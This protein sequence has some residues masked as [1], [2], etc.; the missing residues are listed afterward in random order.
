MTDVTEGS[1]EQRKIVVSPA[2]LSAAD[3]QYTSFPDFEIWASLVPPGAVW[4]DALARL[5]EVRAS[6]APDANERAVTT[7]MRLAAVDTGALEGLY[8]VDRG[9]TYSVAEEAAAWEIEMDR[10]GAHVR[11]LFEAQLRAYELVLDAATS[12]V[13]VSEAFLRRI[14]EEATSAQDTYTVYTAVGPQTRP[15]PRGEYKEHPNHPW[16]LEGLRHAYAPVAMTRPEMHRLVTEIDSTAF[17]AAHPVLQAAYVHYALVQVHPFADGNG[18]ASRAAASIYLYRGGSVPFLLFADQKPAYLD[19][20]IASDEGNHQAFV[21]Y[22]GER[23]VS[24]VN[25]FTEILRAAMS[26]PLDESLAA[27]RNLHVAIGTL[28]YAELDARV[29]AI[30]SVITSAIDNQLAA[31]DLPPTIQ[32]A[33]SGIRPS[34]LQDSEFRAAIAAENIGAAITLTSQAPAEASVNRE[35]HVL[36]ARDRNPQRTYEVSVRG[37]SSIELALADVY[38]DM[39]SDSTYRIETLVRETLARAVH[40]LL[41]SGQERLRSR[42]F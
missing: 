26:P 9:F 24:A 30:T 14:H 37:G 20:L 35:I 18:R 33:R 17:Q 41:Q 32:T 15:L 5:E 29:A 8:S 38:P 21:T 1:D 31:L 39:T 22:V 40:E 36:V 10:R 16:G 28:S 27:L 6:A 2:D 4:T 12:A 11:P 19:A 3:S 25:R 13:P 7:T 34:P 23:A 42:G